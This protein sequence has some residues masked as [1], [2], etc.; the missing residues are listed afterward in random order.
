MAIKQRLEDLE[1]EIAPQSA[2]KYVAYSDGEIRK[3]ETKDQ[4]LERLAAAFGA[5]PDD[6]R[7]YINTGVP[8][9]EGV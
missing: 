2:V 1:A 9:P 8:H 3:G 7:V 5:G 6:E 4:A